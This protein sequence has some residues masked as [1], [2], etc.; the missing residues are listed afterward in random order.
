MTKSMKKLLLTGAT[1]FVGKNILPVLSKQYDVVGVGSKDCDLRSDLS[2]RNLF[3]SVRPDIVVHAA[4]FV[5]GIGLNKDNPGKSIYDN[6]TMGMNVIHQSKEY[7]VSKFVLIGTVCSYP[8]Y[9]SVPFKES[10]LWNGYP[11]V[12]NAPYGVAKKA[13]SETLIA[14]NKQYGM[15]GVNL[16]PVNMYGPYDHFNFSTSHVIPASI[17]KVHEAKKKGD[18]SITIW[19]TGQ[20]SREFLYVEDFVEAV[21]LSIEVDTLPVPI[22]IG[23]GNEIKICELVEMICELMGYDGEIVYD[24][25]KPD[26]QPR[27]CMDTTR[28]KEII[29]FEAKTSFKVGLNKTL[30]YFKDIVI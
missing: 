11:E 15:N 9:T 28:A 17:L 25:S 12:T 20:V 8:K 19:G 26:G 16:L 1:G 18:S 29:G 3:D 13:L 24:T 6:L 14:Y 22:N 30:D 27:R 10:D 21:C 4:G 2:V 23:T 7:D 5:G